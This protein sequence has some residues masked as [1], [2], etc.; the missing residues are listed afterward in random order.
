MPLHCAATRLKFLHVQYFVFFKP[1]LW[2]VLTRFL[3]IEHK[4][5]DDFLFSSFSPLA[6][7]CWL[8]IHFRLVRRSATSGT[9]TEFSFVSHKVEGSVGYETCFAGRR[10]SCSYCHS[11]GGDCKEVLFP[12]MNFM[13]LCLNL[14]SPPFLNCSHIQYSSGETIH[15]SQNPIL[16]R[17]AAR[18][19]SSAFFLRNLCWV[20]TH[21]LSGTHL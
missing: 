11:T 16:F 21:S 15:F 12:T 18:S 9:E 7:W 14:T 17:R 20:D 19:G 1:C 6:F 13:S 10:A 5:I 8:V 2:P 4:N 3:R